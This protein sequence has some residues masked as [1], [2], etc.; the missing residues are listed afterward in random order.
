M[1][2]RLIAP[3]EIAT[4]PNRAA[5]ERD[6]LV[7][8]VDYFRSVLVRKAVGLTQ[9]QMSQR[10]GAST[11]TIGGLLKHSALVEDH[12]FE[13]TW[14]GHDEPEPWAAVDWETTPD[15]DFDSARHDEPTELLALLEESVARSRAAIADSYD[16]DALAALE[17]RLGET[18]L[19]WILVHMIEEYARHCGH[20]DLIR[21][22]IDG[23]TGD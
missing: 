23:Q 1:D 6:T 14:L 20:A 10:N 13:H 18:S 12:W 19:R 17:S 21:E 9:G 7:A 8:F 16:L 11:L 5:G 2:H 3:I 4:E 22:H 15:W